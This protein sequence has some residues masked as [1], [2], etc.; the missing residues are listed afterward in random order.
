MAALVSSLRRARFQACASFSTVTMPLP[1]HS[2]SSVSSMMPRAELARDNIVMRGL[3]ADHHADRD[4]AVV[5]VGSFRGK[6]DGARHFE[7]TGH[8]HDL[9]LRLRR[10]NHRPSAARQL[11]D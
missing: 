11:V 7:G 8:S 1:M 9:I 5:R 10:L 6:G 2:P 4:I 3:A